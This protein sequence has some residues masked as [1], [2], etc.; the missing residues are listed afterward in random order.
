MRIV[1]L[2][3]ASLLAVFVGINAIYMLVS[4]RAWYRL[5]VWLRANGSL[6][7]SKYSTGDGAFTLRTLGLIFFVLIAWMIYDIFI[8]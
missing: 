2:I 5:P 1:G 8:K 3:F 6:P 4:P 7:E